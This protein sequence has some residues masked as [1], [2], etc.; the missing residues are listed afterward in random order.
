MNEITFP[1]GACNFFLAL[2]LTMNACKRVRAL[3]NQF[4]TFLL[5]Y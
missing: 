1:T 2:K 5:F 4:A 3:E